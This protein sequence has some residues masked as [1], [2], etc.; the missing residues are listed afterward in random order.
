MADNKT[1][2]SKRQVKN[3]ETFRERAIKA[4]EVGDKQSF[5]PRIAGKIF[6]FIRA[7]FRAIGRFI[8]KLF[9]YKLTKPIG[10]VF[11]LI[12]KILFPKYFRESWDEL[13]KVTWPNWTQSRR[14]TNAVIIFAVIFGVTVAIIDFFLDKIFRNI[15]L[16]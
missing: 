9:S 15:L 10:K 13:K 6:R 5:V 7:I 2:K 11:I 12:G 16:K 4:S 1:D 14:L 8:K 3:P